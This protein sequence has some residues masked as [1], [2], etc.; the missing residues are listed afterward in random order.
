VTVLGTIFDV[1]AEPTATQIK[2]YEG[3]VGV[4]DSGKGGRVQVGV[5]QYAITG[6]PTLQVG[7][8]ATLPADKLMPSKVTLLPSDDAYLQGGEPYNHD[9]LYVEG[10]RR[11]IFLKF[12][13]QDVGTVLGARLC[14]TQSMDVGSGTL[15]FFEGSP[16][17]WSERTLTPRNAPMPIREIA[18]RTGAVQR[19]QTIEVDMSTLIKGD[20]V[21]TLVITLDEGGPNDIRFG[22]KES[23]VPPKLILTCRRK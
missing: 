5:G 9:C 6:G 10:G 18:R 15:R 7:D 8:L 19:G 23:N 16:K 13:V 11:I 3:L 20:G 4:Q 14:L 22:S 2:V 17:D 1:E 21:Y 12:K